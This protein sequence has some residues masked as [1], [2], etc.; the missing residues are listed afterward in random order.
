MLLLNK[1]AGM[2]GGSS[3][4][5]CEGMGI[6]VDVDECKEGTVIDDVCTDSTGSSNAEMEIG[7]VKGLSIDYEVDTLAYGQKIDI[8]RNTYHR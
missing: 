3:D 8:L 4:V 5:E 2:D 7:T 6:D 1:D